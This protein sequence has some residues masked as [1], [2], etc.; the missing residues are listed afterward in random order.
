MRFNARPI[1]NS[2]KIA[3]NAEVAKEVRGGRNLDLN[4][5]DF[6]LKCTER[7]GEVGLEGRLQGSLLRS[8]LDCLCRK[9]QTH[10]DAEHCVISPIITRIKELKIDARRIFNPPAG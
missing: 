5:G 7:E 6:R 3:S 1:W 4:L 9:L 2:S 8:C 10:R